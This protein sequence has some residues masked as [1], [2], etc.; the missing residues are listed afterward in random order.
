MKLIS[1]WYKERGYK[2]TGKVYPIAGNHEGL[3]CD[4]FDI[5]GKG[6]QWILDNMTEFWG[7]WFTT[8]CNL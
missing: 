8:E 6:H 3:P 1:T 2:G 5:Y 4:S 7:D